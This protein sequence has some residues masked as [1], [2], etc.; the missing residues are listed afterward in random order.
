MEGFH[1]L[2]VLLADNIVNSGFVEGRL[3]SFHV[4]L[5]VG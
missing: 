4:I 1:F 3:S 5:T 2:N